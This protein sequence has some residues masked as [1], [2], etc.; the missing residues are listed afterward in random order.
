MK[1]SKSTRQS[2]DRAREKARNWPYHKI[3]FSDKLAA[4]RRTEKLPR[5]RQR[6]EGQVSGGGGGERRGYRSD[7]RPEKERRRSMEGG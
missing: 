2:G 4:R 5:T 3:I 7:F 1:I 6:R